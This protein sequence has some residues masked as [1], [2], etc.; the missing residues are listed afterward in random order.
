[1]MRPLRDVSIEGEV[2]NVD[3]G[4]AEHVAHFPWRSQKQ[5]WDDF[6]NYWEE[7]SHAKVIALC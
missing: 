4:S 3:S 6:N 5:S 1:M 2:V 7:K